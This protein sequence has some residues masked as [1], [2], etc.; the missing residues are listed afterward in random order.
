MQ[1]VRQIH[2]LRRRQVFGMAIELFHRR[3]DVVAEPISQDDHG[4][5]EIRTVISALH[6]AAMTID[7]VL[8][9]N[10]TAAVRRRVIDDLAFGGPG[11]SGKV[12]ASGDQKCQDLN[13][14]PHDYT[15]QISIA[16]FS[17]AIGSCPA[18]GEYS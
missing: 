6:V 5:N 8:R 9:I 16:L 1:K 11:L 12:C 4:A 18:S 14:P 7:A 3:D 17:V 15:S 2:N 10:G 13:S